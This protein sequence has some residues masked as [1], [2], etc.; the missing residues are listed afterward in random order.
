M[1]IGYYPG[2]SLLGTAREYDQSIRRVFSQLGVNL[3]EIEDWS[4]CGAT[5]AH[6][7]NHLL[8]IA[9][10]LR[11]FNLASRQGMKEIFIPCAACYNRFVM[12]KYTINRDPQMRRDVEA[13]LEEEISTDLR[14]VSMIQIFEKLGKER[15]LSVRQRDLKGFKVAAYYGCLLLR[16]PAAVEFDDAEEPSSMEEIIKSTGAEP[17]NWNFRT[18]CCGASHSI[19]NPDVVISLSK[20]IIDDAAEMGAEAIIVACP[21]C[22]SNLDMRQRNMAKIDAAHKNIPILYL[23]ELIGLSLGLDKEALGLDLHF[24][25]TDPVLSRFSTTLAVKE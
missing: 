2:C 14:L 5:S 7:T 19:T 17:I 1:D 11:N 6:A 21:M 20:R 15:I 3:V 8:S 4:C 9:L 10:P 23:S 24:I 13:I 18:E 12:A 16:P 25:D 22:H